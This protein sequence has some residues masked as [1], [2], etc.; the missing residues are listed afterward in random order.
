MSEEEVNRRLN[1]FE[2]RT[3]A[4]EGRTTGLEGR[5]TTIELKKSD[6]DE[7]S[8]VKDR[9][10]K[11]ENSYTTAITVAVM[12]GLGGAG[13]FGMLWNAKDQI[14]KVQ[15]Q[16]RTLKDELDELNPKLQT[17]KDEVNSAKTHALQEIDST[18]S[19]SV[20]AVNAAK[21]D[22]INAINASASTIAHHVKVN[23][24]LFCVGESDNGCSNLPRWGCGTNA[25]AI[26]SSL[27]PGLN[28]SVPRLYR[29]DA[30]G[31]C[32]YAHYEVTCYGVQ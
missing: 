22:S 10:A 28:H 26:A 4:I 32:G 24:H 1:A 27:C 16:T 8:V 18:R 29:D 14:D 11:L 30:G 17:A 21:T 7:L 12:L 25:E 31:N 23:Y 3:I 20:G 5:T 6:K 2:S 15:T 19:S 9:V 13:L